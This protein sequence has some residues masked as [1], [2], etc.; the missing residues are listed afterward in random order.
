MSEQ[1]YKHFGKPRP[2]CESCHAL[3]MECPAYARTITDARVTVTIRFRWN[4]SDELANPIRILFVEDLQ[5]DA[6]LALHHLKR[7]GMNCVAQRV[8]T[9]AALI[10]ALQAFDPHIIL[11]DFSLPQFDGMSALRI[12][13][14]RAP[15]VPF[16]FVSGTI[17]EE[18]AI[19]ALRSGA[20]DYVLKENLARLA[21][22]VQRALAE[23]AERRKQAENLPPEQGGPSGP[24]P[25]RFGDWERK[26]IA[27][28]F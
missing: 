24:E 8:D 21:P 28:D 20:V 4:M 3:N 12:V 9:E 22:A 7:A 6:D 16:L 27:V 18:R 10:A 23:A 13:T 14:Q 1:S 5:V 17:G 11:S 25:T 15:H 19:N 26:G 2:I